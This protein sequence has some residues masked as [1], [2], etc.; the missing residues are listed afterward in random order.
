LASR[1]RRLSPRLGLQLRE[2]AKHMGI[3]KAG[4]NLR[5]F[6]TAEQIFCIEPASKTKLPAR[7]SSL[8][9]RTRRGSLFWLTRILIYCHACSP[10]AVKRAYRA[11]AQKLAIRFV[12]SDSHARREQSPVHDLAASVI[13][14]ALRER[15]GQIREIVSLVLV[16]KPPKNAL[17]LI[18]TSWRG[19]SRVAP[20]LPE[21]SSFKRY[22]VRRR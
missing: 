10:N 17:A 1:T 21:A 5:I 14:P 8:A 9:L 3:N 16:D 2:D 6:S 20:S 11:N 18:S 7:A 19:R 15:L 4:E 13:L 12:D 22:R